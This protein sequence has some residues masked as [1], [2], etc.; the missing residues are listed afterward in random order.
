MVDRGQ[1]PVIPLSQRQVVS[2]LEGRNIEGIFV[3]KGEEVEAAAP[4]LALKQTETAY[5]LTNNFPRRKKLR[6]RV[7]RLEAEVL[8]IGE[9]RSVLDYLLRPINRV[10]QRAFRE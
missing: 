8:Q 2:Y 5:S 10:S 4:I 6:A 7:V 1:G 3:R 9:Q